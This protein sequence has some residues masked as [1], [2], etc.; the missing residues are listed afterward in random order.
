MSY[1][2][3]REVINATNMARR[4]AIK[5]L[6]DRHRE[7]FNGLYLVEAEKLGLN[8]TKIQAKVKRAKESK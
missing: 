7:E 1:A 3:Y 8:P 6:I 4:A 5:T 2:K